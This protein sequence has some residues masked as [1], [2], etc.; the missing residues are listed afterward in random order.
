MTTNSDHRS[1]NRRALGLM[2][3]GRVE[4]RMVYVDL[5][6]ISEGGCKLKGSAGFADIGDRVTLRIGN[7]QAPVGYVVWVQGRTAGVAFDGKLHEAVLDHLSASQYPDLSAD[8]DW[9]RRV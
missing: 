7:V 2:V 6:D 3:K 5:V 4:S 1:K 9:R 8:R